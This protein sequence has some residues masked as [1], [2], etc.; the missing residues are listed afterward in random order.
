MLLKWYNNIF[1]S[2]CIC[3]R[4]CV[5]VL[6]L[7]VSNNIVAGAQQLTEQEKGSLRYIAGAVISKLYRTMK[8]SDHSNTEL[9]NFL[10]S[11]RVP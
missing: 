11:M 9:Q 5:A 10:L 4:R 3:R 8:K 1:E 6:H 2:V 7:K